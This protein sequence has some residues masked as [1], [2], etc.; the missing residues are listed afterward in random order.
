[1]SLAKIEQID[2]T[3]LLFD[4]DVS[5]TK[6][7]VSE[8][9]V[10]I[11]N[12]E[13]SLMIKGKKT[14]EGIEVTVPKLKGI[15]SEG[16]YTTRL[17]IIIGDRIF[18]PLTEVIEVLPN[19]ELKV[20]NKTVEKVEPEENIKITVGSTK[21]SSV[22]QEAKDQGYIV[23]DVSGKKVLKNESGYVGIIENDEMK[24]IEDTDNG[25][26]LVTEL[27]EKLNA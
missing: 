17:E 27:F 19:I 4:V 2:E 18:K 20:E 22:V 3:K 24:L 26:D 9:R 13:Y 12:E 8:Y 16:V 10:V 15:L 14:G 25:Y 21:V 11:E 5:G 1:M 7:D 6:E 23:V